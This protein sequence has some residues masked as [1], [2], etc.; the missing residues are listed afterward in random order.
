MAK[1]GKAFDPSRARQ[2]PVVPVQ[3]EGAEPS[4]PLPPVPAVPLSWFARTCAR[5]GL[6]NPDDIV[7]FSHSPSN[8]SVRLISGA[9]YCLMKESF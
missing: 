8:V 4:A 7:A 2:E 5:L 6:A 9:E 3:R 1:Q